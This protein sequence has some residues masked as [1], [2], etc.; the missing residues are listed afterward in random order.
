MAALLRDYGGG[1]IRPDSKAMNLRFHWMLPKGG[2]VVAG[3]RQTVQAAARYRLE[4]TS[5]SSPAPRP[6]MAGWVHFVEHAE[7]AGIDSILISFSRYEPDPL[8]VSCALGQATRK[9]KFISAYRSGLIQPTSFVQ[10]VNTLS[11]LMP[12][13]VALNI[14]AGSSKAEQ[15]GYGD[16]LPH[17]ERYARAE[18]FLTVCR[19]FWQTNEAVNFQGKYYQVDQGRLQ[20]PFAGNGATMPEIYVS[21]H[22]EPAERVAL[23]GATCLLRVADTPEKLRPLVARIRAHGLE[24]CLRMEVLCRP[25]REEAI[26]TAESLL[27]DRNPTNGNS[28]VALKDDSQ[29]YR[30][31]RSIPDTPDHWLNDSL[32]TG[33]VPHYG[34]VWTTLLG[35]PQCLANAFLAYKAI[36]VT[37]FIM[38][39]WP[40]L[41][42][43]VTFGRE[44]LP[45]VRAAELEK[46]TRL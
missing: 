33:L 5:R 13:R 20:T 14:V 38:S 39:G 37:Q 8:V 21:G 26:S 24:V 28:A 46:Q 16:Y 9:M 34:P 25:T 2:E 19:L 11:A 3:E 32:W 44:V 27:P 12:G 36:G 31:G 35:T 22:S 23:A 29:M 40:E 4:S 17:D 15:L 1:R 10:Q 6:D 7:E 42:E 30:E 43:V 41:D 18:E 45:L